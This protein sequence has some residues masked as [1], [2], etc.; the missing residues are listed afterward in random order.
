M[1]SAAACENGATLPCI[2]IRR[3]HSRRRYKWRD[4]GESRRARGIDVARGALARKYSEALGIPAALWRSSKGVFPCAPA[5]VI[6]SGAGPL[7]RAPATSRIICAA[8]PS[9]TLACTGAWWHGPA[10]RNIMSLENNVI[11]GHE[12]K[13]CAFGA[14]TRASRKRPYGIDGGRSEV[15]LHGAR[16]E[17]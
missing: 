11:A 16:E 6:I 13:S 9:P 15:A 3:R 14:G 5:F 12:R 10:I 4:I 17:I 8:A 7:L 1:A 2:V